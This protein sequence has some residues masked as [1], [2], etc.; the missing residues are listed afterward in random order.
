MARFKEVAEK[1]NDGMRRLYKKYP[2]IPIEQRPPSVVR[3]L[4]FTKSTPEGERAELRFEA[5]WDLY[6][7]GKVSMERV[8]EC[9]KAWVDAH[10]TWW[11]GAIQQ[12]APK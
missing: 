1:Y 10:S 6:S 11:I 4:D 8:S 3:Q 12:E 2:P 7:R 5:A 9:F